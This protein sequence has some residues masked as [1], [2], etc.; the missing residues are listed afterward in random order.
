MPDDCYCKKIK[1]K[2]MLLGYFKILK[3]KNEKNMFQPGRNET[4]KKNI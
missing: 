4:N 3:E 2:K 1:Y